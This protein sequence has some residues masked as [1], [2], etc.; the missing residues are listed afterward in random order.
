MI[1]SEIASLTT[2]KPERRKAQVGNPLESSQEHTH[3][4]DVREVLYR[5]D[6]LLILIQGDSEL[7]PHCHLGMTV[8]RVHIGDMLI[9][10]IV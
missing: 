1:I 6:F 8:A 10:D 4:T 5:T 2:D 9:G 3:I 7:V